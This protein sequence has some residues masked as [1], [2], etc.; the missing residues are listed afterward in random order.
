MGVNSLVPL[1]AAFV[2]VVLLLALIINRQWQKQHRLFA[3][4]LVGAMLWSFGTF[5]LR[6]D[7]LVEYKM[8]LFRIV[9]LSSLWWIVQLYYFIRIFLKMPGGLGIWFGYT[10]L[11]ISTVFAILGVWPLSLSFNNGMIIPNWGW[12]VFQYVITQETFA[13]L[14]FYFVVKRFVVLV[15]PKERNKVAYLIVAMSLLTIFGFIGI[16]PLA[17]KFPFSLFGGL[18]SAFIFTYAIMKHELVSINS[19]LRQSLTWISLFVIGTGAYLLVFYFLYLVFGFDLNPIYLVVATLTAV[20]VAVFVYWLR[21]IFFGIVNQLLSRGTYHYRQALLDFSIKMGNI[22]NLNELADEMLPTISRA[23]RTKQVRL[24]LAD[25]ANGDFTTQFAYPKKNDRSKKDPSFNLDNPIVSWL[26]TKATPIDLKR[27]DAIPQFKGLW[28]SE[29]KE[30]VDFNLDLLCPIKSRGD[31]IGIL[32]LSRKQSDAHYSQEDIELLVSLANGAGIIIEN[33]RMFD[34][35]KTQQHMV[36]QLLAQAVVAQE[37]ERERISA[38]LHD[39]VAQWL[40]AASYRAQ[41]CSQLLSGNGNNTALEELTNMEDTLSKSVKELRRV[42]IGLRPPALDELGLTHALRQSLDELKSDGVICKYWETGTPVRLPISVEIAVYRVVQETVTN[43]RKHANATKVS[44]R[45]DFNEDNLLVSIRD[46]GS[47]FN[48]GQTLSSA[49]SV[50]R[51]GLLG[52]RQR[53]EMLG[54]NMKIK[55]SE[56]AGTMITLSF[57]ILAPVGEH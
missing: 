55:T 50:G 2:Y 25:D 4:Y 46:N 14:G 32:A 22:I 19:I 26:D 6:S 23:L 44:L 49:I 15:E 39:S 17:D 27:I 36:E 18:L 56:G 45:L 30:L 33:A 40:V 11:A 24:L 48:L 12:F 13:V 53:M 21:P 3:L 34:S 28:Q 54:G 42:V 8:L 47:G 38:D 37:N 41:T 52:M 9:I 10:S 16:S 29:I 7:L 31:L 51:V 1:G 35:L 5:L 57:P 20:A 43:I